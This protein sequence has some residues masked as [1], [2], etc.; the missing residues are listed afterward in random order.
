MVYFTLKGGLTGFVRAV[1]ALFQK[2]YGQVEKGLDARN[3]KFCKSPSELLSS[4]NYHF[5]GSSH[6]VF[7][8]ITTTSII[9]PNSTSLHHGE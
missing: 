8:A 1:E 3:Q 6:C 9:Y 7:A 5:A 4:L 2:N